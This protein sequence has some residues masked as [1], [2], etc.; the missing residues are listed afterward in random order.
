MKPSAKKEHAYLAPAQLDAALKQI[1]TYAEKNKNNWSQIKQAEVDV[2]LV[3]SDYIIEGK[4][5]LIRG[6]DNSV[7][8]VDFKSEK[9]PDEN[10]QDRLEHYRRQLHIYAYL[11]EQRMGQKV[12]NMNLYYTGS[13]E[14]PIIRF[15]YKKT[16]IEETIAIFDKTVHNI[17]KHNY[18]NI[19]KDNRTCNN[20]DFK[21]YC[22]NRQK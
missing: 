18:K 9:K 19:S 7:E 16:A 3:K 14:E 10:S 15:P 12:S 20:C 2:S 21:H 5:D 11:V 1:K 22:K 17:M 8:I 6:D 4:I 13:T